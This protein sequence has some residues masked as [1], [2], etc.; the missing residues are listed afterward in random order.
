VSRRGAKIQVKRPYHHGRLREVVLEAA[1][2]EIEAVGAARMSMR[3][4]AKRAGV[5]HAAPAHH[6]G[7]KAGIFTAIA[8]EGYRLLYEAGIAAAEGPNAFLDTGIAYITFALGHRAHFEVMFRP[9]LCH[10]DDPELVAARDQ[11]FG[12][13]FGIVERDLKPS[14]DDLALPTSVAAWSIVHGFATLWLY[15]NLE[16]RFGEGVAFESLIPQLVDGFV[17]LGE[18]AARGLGA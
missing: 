9:D 16:P 12:V 3:E 4:I 13:L 2:E 11:S 15:G 7:D 6:F 17:A 14:R 10:T 8:A 18:I 1:L 5:S